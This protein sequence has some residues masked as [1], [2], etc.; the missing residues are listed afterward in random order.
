[1]NM[2]QD[3]RVPPKPSDQIASILEVE[4]CKQIAVSTKLSTYHHYYISA[5][6][7]VMNWLG[8]C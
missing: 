8:N 1:M 2:M 6:L 3:E 7:I 4:T 5:L